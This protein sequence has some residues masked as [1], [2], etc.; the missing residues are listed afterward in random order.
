MTRRLIADVVFSWMLFMGIL[1][2]SYAADMRNGGRL[3]AMHCVACHGADGKSVMPEAP[4]FA[5]GERLLQS[6]FSLLNVMRIGRGA[7]PGYM[8][9]LSD[10][11]I[12]D[13]ISFLRTLR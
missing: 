8:G 9:I 7:M 3:Y 13:V 6:D 10:R 5:R 12:L 2:P 11:E 1:V 4:N